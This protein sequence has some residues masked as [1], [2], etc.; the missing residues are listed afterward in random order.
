ML[1][2][3]DAVIIW[4]SWIF[5]VHTNMDHMRDPWQL[6]CQVCNAV[7]LLPGAIY[8]RC[9][10]LQT[11]TQTYTQLIAEEVKQSMSAKELTSIPSHLQEMLKG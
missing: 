6:S 7:H 3:P 11:Y 9:A 2:H 1:T 8:R 10:D 4:D 5:V